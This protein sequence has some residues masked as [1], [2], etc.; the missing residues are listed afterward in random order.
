MLVDSIGSDDI[1]GHLLV[2]AIKF[3]DFLIY[4]VV[5]DFAIS[6]FIEIKAPEHS[7]LKRIKNYRIYRGK[8]NSQFFP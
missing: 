8:E 3:S 2:Y 7:T 1:E 4:E 5:Y 6:Y